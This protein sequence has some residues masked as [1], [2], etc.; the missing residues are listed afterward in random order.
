M[1]A[2]RYEMTTACNAS[3]CAGQVPLSCSINL[4]FT[5]FVLMFVSARVGARVP[6]GSQTRVSFSNTALTALQSSQATR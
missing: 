6:N 4:F 2:T 3:Y 5:G 1:L